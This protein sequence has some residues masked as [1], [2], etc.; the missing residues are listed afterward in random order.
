MIRDVIPS[1]LRRLTDKILE[2]TNRTRIVLGTDRKDLISSG[3]GD[4]G[5]NDV[6]SGAIDIV[7]GYKNQNPSFQEDRARIY[8]SSK[9]NPDENLELEQ[10]PKVQGE[11]VI[12]S[13]AENNYILAA[14]NLKIL[15]GEN[16]ILINKDGTIQIQSNNSVDIKSGQLVINISNGEIS[17]GTE[18]GIPKRILTEG[19]VCVGVAPSGGGPVYSNFLAPGALIANQNVKI[20]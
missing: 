6:E 5:Q 8:L 7:A 11:S 14:N 15:C 17:L 10:G 12:I 1:F 16:T 4:G 13:K 18:T 19:D 2:G 9:S 3:Y 20:K